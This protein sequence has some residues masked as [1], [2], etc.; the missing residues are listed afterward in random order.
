MTKTIHDIQYSLIKHELDIK[1]NK[2]KTIIDAVT[3]GDKKLKE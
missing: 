2:E 3:E 1:K